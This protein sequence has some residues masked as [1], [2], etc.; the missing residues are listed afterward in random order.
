MLQ[1]PRQRPAA[2]LMP[3][4]LQ[5]GAAQRFIQQPMLPAPGQGP[6]A[7]LMLSQLQLQAGQACLPSNWTTG[8][9]GNN[10][11]GKT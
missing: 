5:F 9:A 10:P 4:Q 2:G 11:D 7:G 6:A 1:V 3:S 8:G